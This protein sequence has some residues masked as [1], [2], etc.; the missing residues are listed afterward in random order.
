MNKISNTVSMVLAILIMTSCSSDSSSPPAPVLAPIGD[1]SGGW[2]IF[3][4]FISS[5]AD[6]SDTEGYDVTITQNGSSITVTGAAGGGATG[7]LSGSALS[8]TGSRQPAGEIGTVTYSSI[9]ATIP[10]DCSSFTAQTKWTYAE[11]GF[12]CSG[13]STIQANRTSGG[14]TC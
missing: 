13:D 12:S 14:T 5:N 9:T 11:P 7:T 4:T 3:E 8:L 10:S 6:C 2:S 1:I